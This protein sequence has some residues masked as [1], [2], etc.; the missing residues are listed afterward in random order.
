MTAMQGQTQF[1]RG[2]KAEKSGWFTI[3]PL[4]A[5]SSATRTS[6]LQV[7]PQRSGLII[8]VKTGTMTGSPVWTPSLAVVSPSGDTLTLW[9][10]AATIVTAT[11]SIY[12]FDMGAGYTGETESILASVPREWK[13]VLTYAG[14][15]ANDHGATEVYGMYI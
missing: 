15:P 14:T 6:D 12:V 5:G 10:A 13:F 1:A 9:T 7:S 4:Q 8:H 3:L 11:G 2:L